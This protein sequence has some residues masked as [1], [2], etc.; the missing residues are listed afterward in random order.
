MHPHPQLT[1][2]IS[3]TQLTG[4]V[5]SEVLTRFVP[6]ARENNFL[7]KKLDVFKFVSLVCN[8]VIILTVCLNLKINKC[9]AEVNWCNHQVVTDV[10]CKTE[11]LCACKHYGHP[12]G[13]C[14]GLWGP[15]PRNISGA[16]GNLKTIKFLLNYLISVHL[17][18]NSGNPLNGAH[19]LI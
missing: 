4:V 7:S 10:I 2:H 16:P 15:M 11:C 3:V 9:L 18:N 8:F 17:W 6:K 12:P 1:F 19:K 5:S 14:R 13:P